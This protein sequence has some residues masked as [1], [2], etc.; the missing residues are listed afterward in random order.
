MLNAKTFRAIQQDL[1]EVRAARI[2][3]EL[4]AGLYPVEVR[5]ACDKLTA[6]IKSRFDSGS[7]FP[8]DNM[9]IHK[10]DLNLNPTHTVQFVIILTDLGYSVEETERALIL[11][12]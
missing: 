4:A 12:W 5:V 1:I 8:G 7:P 10:S 6:N 3:R 9:M 2:Q 11:R